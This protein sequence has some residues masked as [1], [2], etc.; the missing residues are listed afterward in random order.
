ML[1]YAHMDLR[2]ALEE[3]P[4]APQEQHVSL[5]TVVLGVGTIIAIALILLI[6]VEGRRPVDPTGSENTWGGTGGV[7]FWAGIG[8]AQ[9]DTRFSV[10]EYLAKQ[11][12]DEHI[13][14]PA[15][16]QME[17]APAAPF[18]LTTLLGSIVEPITS[19]EPSAPSA[20]EF[21]PRGFIST[22]V[23]T[24]VQTEFQEELYRYGNTLGGYLRTF[25]DSHADVIVVLRDARED[26]GNTAK[27]EAA[28]SIGTDYRFLA[29]ELH[30]MASV[31]EAAQTLHTAF[32]DANEKVGANLEVVARSTNEQDLVA[33]IEV[34]N[35]SVDVYAQ[36]F[37]ALA[38]LFV[39]SG[40]TFSE[41]DP[42]SAFSF[43]GTMS[44]F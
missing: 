26:L 24:E 22:D 42:G 35:A 6:L 34:Y 17:E 37:V 16:S 33:A 8:R 4:R 39:A 38:S 30:T 23:Q 11:R 7:E 14:Q 29:E 18:D 1:H 2:D 19:E 15:P 43:R 10:E 3:A 9:E 27:A 41:G 25:E 5:R 31:P 21:L 20:Y 28:A 32:A 12:Q 13:P 40:V 44:A 36:K